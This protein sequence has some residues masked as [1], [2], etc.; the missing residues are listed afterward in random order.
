MVFER[1]LQG[2]VLQGFAGRQPADPKVG[3]RGQGQRSTAEMVVLADVAVRHSGQAASRPRCAL[4]Q[5]GGRQRRRLGGVEVDS[6]PDRARTLSSQRQLRGEPVRGH[7]RVGV[8]AGNESVR[9]SGV[10]E[11]LA[12]EVHSHLARMA[13]PRHLRLEHR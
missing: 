11:P 3:T 8:G 10:Q 4:F 6:P 2:F 1:T 12:R 5:D 7:L 9:A 13:R